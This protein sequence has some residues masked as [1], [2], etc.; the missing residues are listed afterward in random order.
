VRRLSDG[1]VQRLCNYCH[2]RSRLGF[3][4]H[5]RMGKQALSVNSALPLIKVD[6]PTLLLRL[7]WASRLL[8]ELFMTLEIQSS[9]IE[10]FKVFLIE[11]FEQLCFI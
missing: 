3:G 8:S 11:K 5:F 10:T 7:T 9:P 6:F 1:G 4:G 2:V